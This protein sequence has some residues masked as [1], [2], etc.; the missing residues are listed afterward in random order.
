VPADYY[1]EP[2]Y[3]VELD[4]E[5]WSAL[6]L[7][8]TDLAKAVADG[9]AKLAKGDPQAVAGVFDLFDKFEPARNYKLPTLED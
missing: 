2:D 4:G 3:V 1:R 5:S 7:S 9:K 8:S 6:Y